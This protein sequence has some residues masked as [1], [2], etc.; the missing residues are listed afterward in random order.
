MTIPTP[1]F[2]DFALR[3]I[4]GE[5]LPMSRFDGQVVLLVNVAS[6]CGFTPQYEGLERL[7]R[8]FGDRGLVIL[9]CPCDQFGAQEPGDEA[10]IARFCSLTYDVTF[11]LSSKLD[12]NGDAADPLWQWVKAE[13]P[14]VLGT[15]SVKWN[16]T[17]FLIGRDG[18]VLERFAPTV[19]P[20]ELVAPVEQALAAPPVAG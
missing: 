16:F 2:R 12:V 8:R 9:G 6:Q 3:S 7:W 17:K 11:P 1:A 10:E 18:T 20:D 19:T 15:T 4:D 5:P 14:G 13:E